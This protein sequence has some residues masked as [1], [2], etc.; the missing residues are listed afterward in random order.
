MIERADHKS[1]YT[2]IDN[3]IFRDRRLSLRALGLLCLMLSMSDTWQFNVKDLAKRCGVSAGSI[4]ATLRELSAAGHLVRRREHR[5]D[6]TFGSYLYTV[7]EVPEPDRENTC[8]GE[9]PD[10]EK[11][12]TG[13]SP[14]R[15]KTCAGESPVM[16]NACAGKSG[17]ISN[18]KE[19]RNTKRER[20]KSGF[21]PPT[22]GQVR[23]YCQGQGY[24][25]DPERFV[26][27]YEARGWM[28]GKS[29][30]KSWQAAVRNWSRKDRKT[31][32]KPPVRDSWQLTDP[33]TWRL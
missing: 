27:Y 7:Y 28:L 30:M 11:P 33:S 26:D 13:E 14:G 12:C 22:V 3:S 4:T 2:L 32:E 18:T 5:E 15:E 20:S 25:I 16:V 6:G 1:N 8:T 24:S 10:M 29:K 21:T 17:S 9:S 31:E 23:D 19:E